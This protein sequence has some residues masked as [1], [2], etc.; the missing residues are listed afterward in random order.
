MNEAVGGAPIT[1]VIPAWNP[2]GRIE[3]AVS[4]V[5]PQLEDRDEVIV[6]DDGSDVPIAH[7]FHWPNQVRVV[8]SDP[9]SGSPG[10]PRNIGVSLAKG[11]WIAFLDYDDWWLPRKVRYQLELHETTG[12]G[13]MSAAAVIDGDS[14]RAGTIQPIGLLRDVKLKHLVK[15]N[16]LNTSSIFVLKSL[17]D[18][19]MPFPESREIYEDWAMWLRLASLELPQLTAEPLIRYTDSPGS[20]QRSRY[21]DHLTAYD[22]TV[23]DFLAWRRMQGQTTSLRSIETA[24]R[25]HRLRLSVSRF[26]D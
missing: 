22:N 19:A 18:K 7:R 2:D 11:A 13:F 20:S 26:F 14:S 12:S 15:R 25:L 8:R 24:W 16:C 17:L 9:P 10:R 23:R 6:V 4:S 1:V 21:P 5:L 3:R